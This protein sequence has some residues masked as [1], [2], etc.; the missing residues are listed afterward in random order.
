[1]PHQVAMPVRD[2]ASDEGRMRNPPTARELERSTLYS[3]ELGIDL[4]KG[5]DGAYFRWLLASLLFGGRISETIARNT[6]HAF[7]RRHLLTPREILAAGWDYLVDPVMREGGYVRYDGRKSAQ[8][9][10]D[11]RTLLDDYRGSLARLHEAASDER[12]LEARLL[13]FHGVGPI[14]ANI[15]L[16]ELR[17]YWAKADPEP[18]PIVRDMAAVLRIPL[19]RYRRKSRAFVRLEAGLIRLRRERIAAQPRAGRPFA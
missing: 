13:A 17:P 11:C 12:D 16:R 6:F 8:I 3:E 2:P 5:G 10:R 19:E 4:A 18:L 15:F 9:L 1:M 14:T 7:V